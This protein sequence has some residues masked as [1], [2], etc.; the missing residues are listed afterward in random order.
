MNNAQALTKL[1]KLLGSK[2]AI[3]D[4]KRAS[5]PEQR[6]QEHAAR[7]AVNERKRAAQDAMEAR[8]AAILAGDAEYQR[9]KGEYEVARKE[10]ERTPFG[11]YHRY[12]AGRINDAGGLSFFVVESEADTL[13]EL[14][15]A[16]EVK[17]VSA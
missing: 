17:K 1:R 10:Q 6:E 15:E 13:A 11:T 9:L 3:R 12:T 2:A 7:L 16:V 5:S 8:R 14:I 4:S